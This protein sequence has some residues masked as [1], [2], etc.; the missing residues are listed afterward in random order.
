MKEENLMKNA[1]WLFR[2][3]SIPGSAGWETG[4]DIDG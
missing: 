1:Y 3:R 4:G 2:E